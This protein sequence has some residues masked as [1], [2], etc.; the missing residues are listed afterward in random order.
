MFFID[1]DPDIFAVTET[2]LDLTVDNAELEIDGYNLYRKDRNRH[3]GGV[4][5]YIRSVI[6][7]NLIT[8]NNDI[9]SLWL[10]LTLKHRYAIGCLYRPPSS[11]KDY[12]DK[13][14]H[15]IEMKNLIPR[16][17]CTS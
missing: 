1:N 16:I 12:H 15:E 6:P 5:I 13:I 7:H 4:A 8:M 9:E 11:S 2:F 14:I 3:G 10:E 17:F